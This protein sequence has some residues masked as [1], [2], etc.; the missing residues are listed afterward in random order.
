MGQAK[1]LSDISAVIGTRPVF[2]CYDMD[3]FDPSVAPGV[4]TPTPG[5]A[6]PEEGLALMAGLKGLNIIGID[7]NTVTPMHDPSGATAILAA[8]LLA[9]GLAVLD[10]K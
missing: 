4:A 8:S 5:G 6:M 2:V 1:L 10:G 3:F 7:V 9:E